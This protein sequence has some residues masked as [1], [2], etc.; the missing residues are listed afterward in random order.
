M[1]FN[2]LLCASQSILGHTFINTEI[3]E[4]RRPHHQLHN[5]LVNVISHGGLIRAA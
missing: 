3:P 5:N 4:F 2:N 1:N